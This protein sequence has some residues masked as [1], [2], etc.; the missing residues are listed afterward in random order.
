[1]KVG[2]IAAIILTICIFLSFYF[3]SLSFQEINNASKKQLVTFAASSLITGVM[4]LACFAVYS[5][6][7]KLF[8]I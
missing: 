3:T 1:L 2:S 6:I 7:K 5:G 4:I 8:T